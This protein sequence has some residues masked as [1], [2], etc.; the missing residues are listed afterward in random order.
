MALARLA[1]TAMIA[2]ESDHPSDASEDQLRL[3][4]KYLPDFRQSIAQFEDAVRK[5]IRAKR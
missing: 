5:E 4:E 1:N 2:P 3:L